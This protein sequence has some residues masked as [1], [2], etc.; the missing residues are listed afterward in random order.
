MMCQEGTPFNDNEDMIETI[1]VKKD[2][3]DKP[4]KMI[5]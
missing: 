2:L 5:L 1:E 3:L 4:T